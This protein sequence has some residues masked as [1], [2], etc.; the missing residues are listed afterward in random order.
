MNEYKAG[1]YLKVLNF[2]LCVG[3][4]A[5]DAGPR[6]AN[7]LELFLFEGETRR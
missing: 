2:L 1:I 4:L 5:F 3:S 7:G 6:M